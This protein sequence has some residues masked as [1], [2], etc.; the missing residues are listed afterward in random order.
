MLQSH[1]VQDFF[2]FL[3]GL[4]S[5]PMATLGISDAVALRLQSVIQ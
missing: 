1:F 2:F 4:E 3:T 5:C